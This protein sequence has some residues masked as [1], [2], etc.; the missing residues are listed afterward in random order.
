MAKV[1]LCIILA[2]I[3][4]L[5]VLV[6]PFLAGSTTTT[7]IAGTPTTVTASFAESYS[8]A[9][10]CVAGG[11]LAVIVAILAALGRVP[12]LASGLLLAVFAILVFIGFVVALC[13]GMADTASRAL[14]G[15]AGAQAAYL[16]GGGTGLV[17]TSSN[18]ALGIGGYCLGVGF[19]LLALAAPLAA[20]KR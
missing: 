13:Q 20:L 4:G 14:V 19:V 16:A 6:G 12:A 17:P 11:L 9:Y 15:G 5:L 3:G 1:K 10:L 7:T 18:M 8:I 2:L